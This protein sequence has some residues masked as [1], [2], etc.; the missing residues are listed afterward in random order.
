VGLLVD[1]DEDAGN[2]EQDG[3]ADGVGDPDEGCCYERHGDEALGEAVVGAEAG[4]DVASK[5][6]AWSVDVEVKGKQKQQQQASFKVA[7]RL[8]LEAGN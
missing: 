6:L 4:L 8:G 1:E 5:R 7:S 2:E 3:Q